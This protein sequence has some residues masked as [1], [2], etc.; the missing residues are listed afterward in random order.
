MFRS[1]GFAVW[2][3]SSSRC[4]VFIHRPNSTIRTRSLDGELRF[5]LDF[6]GSTVYADLPPREELISQESDFL[7]QVSKEEAFGFGCLM[8]SWKET[9]LRNRRVRLSSHELIILH[10]TV[11]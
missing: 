3:S 6:S 9:I 5:V 10:T 8:L 2:L 7:P 11:C 1:E 4:W